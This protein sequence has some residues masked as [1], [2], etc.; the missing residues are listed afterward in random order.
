MEDAKEEDA[1]HFIA[2]VPVDG[3]LYELDGLKAGP[4]PLGTC[5]EVRPFFRL[6]GFFERGHVFLFVPHVFCKQGL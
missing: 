4:V 1:F 2:Y 6:R 3:T 5:T